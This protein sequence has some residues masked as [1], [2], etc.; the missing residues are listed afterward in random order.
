[1]EKKSCL[2]AHLVVCE[3]VRACEELILLHV[4]NEQ[5]TILL[6]RPR[7]GQESMV[8]V[9]PQRKKRRLALT[10]AARSSL[11]PG[12]HLGIIPRSAR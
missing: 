7:S 2:E 8:Q 6:C 12:L 11:R 1:M 5:G 3:S 10:E 9:Q 4:C